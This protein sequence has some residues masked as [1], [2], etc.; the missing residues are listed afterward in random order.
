MFK[1]CILER[2]RTIKE[3]LSVFLTEVYKDRWTLI[4][5]IVGIVILFF[6]EVYKEQKIFL[7]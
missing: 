2:I 1:E 5:Y 6:S 4:F 3:K 7:Y